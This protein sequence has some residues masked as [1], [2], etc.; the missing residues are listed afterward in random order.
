VLQSG[1]RDIQRLEAQLQ[2]E[3]REVEQLRRSLEAKEELVI[4]LDNLV[5]D[6]RSTG[7]KQQEALEEV[8]ADLKEK[9]RLFVR[10]FST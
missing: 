8:E 7:Q 4:E 2:E 3:V 10:Y 5:D 6:L 1:V 9:V